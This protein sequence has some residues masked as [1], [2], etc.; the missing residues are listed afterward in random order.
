MKA[1]Q[2]AIARGERLFNERQFVISGVSGF[3]DTPGRQQFLGTCSSCHNAANVGSFTLNRTM[4]LGVDDF[5]PRAS[6][7]PLYT[8]RNIATGEVRTTS[9]PGRALVT[10]KW[11]DINQFKV[12][13][14]RGLGARGRYFHDGSAGSLKELVDF[15][16]GRFGMILN[17]SEEQDLIAF[18]QAL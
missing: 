6:G 2:G 18:L 5:F 8:L 13:S 4:D 15:Y 1:A 14:L 16:I 7:Q 17:S 10:G 12:P 3:N 9:D 11:K